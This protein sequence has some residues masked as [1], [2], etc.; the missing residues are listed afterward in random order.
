MPNNSLFVNSRGFTLIELIVGIVVLSI[1]LSIISTLIAPAEQKSADHILQVKAAELGQSFLNDINSRAFDENS[2]MA[3]GLVRCGEPNA[4]L[5]PCSPI[6]GPEDGNGGRPDKGETSRDLFNDVD[7][8]HEYSLNFNA[9]NEGLHSSYTN[10][11]IDVQVIYDGTSLGLAYNDAK[12]I[13]VT[14]TTPLGTAIEFAT[15]RANF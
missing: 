5:N 11:T 7:D 9:N 3:G 1:S 10:F 8:F 13:T 12:R 14:I 6:L 4:V 15:H 2:D